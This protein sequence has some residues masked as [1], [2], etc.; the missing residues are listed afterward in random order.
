MTNDQMT[1]DQV[2]TTKYRYRLTFRKGYRVKYVA[3]LD[4]VKMWTR[5]FRRAEIPL[6]YSGGFNPQAK[7]QIAASLPVGSM[8]AAEVM[9]IYLT[10]EM[11]PKDILT[12]VGSTLPPDFA[13]LRVESVDLK[14]PALQAQLRRA[15]YKV[16][17]TSNLP[18]QTLQKRINALLQAETLPQTRIRR[19]KTERFDM[20]PLLHSLNLLTSTQNEATLTMR[21]SAGQQGNLRPDAVLKALQLDDGWRQT[22]RTKLI[23]NI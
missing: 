8:G 13:L 20:R 16:I 10:R 5:A 19:R 7:I 15:D 4:T 21:L 17:V 11:N 23:F 9:D 2:Q 1:N 3:H 22:E 14:A 18:A 12:R 6:A